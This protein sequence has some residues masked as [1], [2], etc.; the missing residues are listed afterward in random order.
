M[1]KSGVVGGGLDLSPVGVFVKV[2]QAGS[3]SI[4]AK[5]LGMPNSTVSAH[6]SRLER[7]L[8]VTLLHRT[9]RRL[10]LTEAGQ[11]FFDRAAE[12]IEMLQN[13]ES[14]AS[15]TQ[16]TPKGL[17]RVTTASDILPPDMLATLMADFQNKHP[18]ISLEIDLTQR[19][20]DLA[21]EGLDVAI[22]AT[23]LMHSRLMARR[24]GTIR[25]VLV[26]SEA[27]LGGATP[28]EHPGD[29]KDHTL[30]EFY[31][32]KPRNWCLESAS[33]KHAPISLPGVM[34]VNH[35]EVIKHLLLA[36]R[37]IALLPSYYIARELEG[38]LLTRILPQCSGAEEAIYVAY[39]EQQ[40]VA[41]RTRAF[42]DFVADYFRR[43]TSG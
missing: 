42:I 39:P 9:T 2:V 10:D 7:R 28:I 6:V 13:A 1:A 3:F 19:M 18:E 32:R 40:F 22:R 41:A 25:W 34:T 36:G 31:G 21:H 14:N 37:G 29:L 33:A 5:Q 4:A 43:Y 15:I 8:G 11:T 30:I 35:L 27:Y 20:V 24:V 23:S 12:G 17:V 38:G 16:L 26:A